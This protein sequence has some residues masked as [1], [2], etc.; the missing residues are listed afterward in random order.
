MAST[1]GSGPSA[2][3]AQIRTDERSGVLHPR[4]LVRFA[5]RWL[6]PAG[7]V[8]GVVDRY[9][10]VR[11]GL[12][13]AER[14]IQTIVDLP[15]VTVTVEEGDVPAR[16]VVTGPHRRAWERTLAG[17][18]SVFALRLRPAGL[19]VLSDL[20]ARELVDV[21]VPLTPD[22]DERLHATMTEIAGAATPEARA[23]AADRVLRSRLGSRPIAPD[24]RL[25]NA[26]VDELFARLRSRA[27]SSLA[28]RFGVSERA[29]QRALASTLGQGPK[30]VSRRI[31]LQEVARLLADD[32]SPDLATLAVEL[33]YTDQAHLVNDFRRTTGTT[34][35]RYRDD[36]RAGTRS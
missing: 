4:N 22:L 33:G 34:P 1:T 13:P 19:A 25:A 21:T 20:D 14:L 9:W 7:D 16:L 30:A 24:G 11:W 28:E 31:R 18:G 2:T 3:T 29:V 17:A 15:A 10:H 23:H 5:A 32:E 8:T 35:G 6:E 26:V 36:V 12:A 27:G